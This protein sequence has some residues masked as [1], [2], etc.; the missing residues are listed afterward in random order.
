MPFADN[1]SL[2]YRLWRR[3][4]PMAIFGIFV[5]DLKVPSRT[6]GFHGVL[7][8][9]LPA[10]W[11]FGCDFV[12]DFVCDFGSGLAISNEYMTQSAFTR[13]SCLRMVRYPY[14][15]KAVVRFAFGN[16]F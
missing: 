16:I 10:R 1:G 9:C 4:M 12:C 6:W 2:L 5:G 14:I 7:L 15:F 8:L 3:R 11:M 13:K